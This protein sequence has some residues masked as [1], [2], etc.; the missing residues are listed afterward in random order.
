M[1]WSEWSLNLWVIFL[2][3]IRNRMKAKMIWWS[4]IPASKTSEN[5]LTILFYKIWSIRVTVFSG[6]LVGTVV[7]WSKEDLN[8]TSTNARSLLS[9]HSKL[10]FISPQMT[11]V[12]KFEI[13][14]NK[15]SVSEV[16]RVTLLWYGGRYTEIIFT[17]LERNAYGFIWTNSM[18]ADD[19]LFLLC[20]NLSFF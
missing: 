8:I 13:L 6:N 11:V 5:I 16:N 9:G 4:E 10:I 14:F 1:L 15:S 17:F 3:I 19:T 7:S 20:G 2:V 18:L 12:S